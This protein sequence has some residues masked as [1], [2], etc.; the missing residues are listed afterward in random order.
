[1]GYRPQEQSLIEPID[2][3]LEGVDEFEKAT[4]KRIESKEWQT[5]HIEHLNNFRKQFLD[6]SFQL[7]KLQ[8]ETW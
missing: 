4:K 1:M 8:E 2:K 6:L 7:R 3:I 5:E